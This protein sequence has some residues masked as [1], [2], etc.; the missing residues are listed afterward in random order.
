MDLSKKFPRQILYARKTVLGVR[1]MK[2]I[3]MIV[4]LALKLYIG[5]K[6]FEMNIGKMININKKIAYFQY[7]Y[8]TYQIITP[9]EYKPK[10]I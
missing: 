1:L 9:R 4:I 10:K 2:P 8:K 5:Y 3:I 7:G 6:R